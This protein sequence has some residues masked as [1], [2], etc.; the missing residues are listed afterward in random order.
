[1]KNPYEQDEQRKE[2]SSAWGRTKE[3]LLLNS[4][5]RK[6]YRRSES[7]IVTESDELL[8]SLQKIY[9]K[10]ITQLFSGQTF[11]EIALLSNAKNRTCTCVTHTETEMAIV[12]KQD[13]VY[14][15]QQIQEEKE[16]KN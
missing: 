2:I 6:F 16:A 10:Y 1:M 4:R 7:Q 12:M 11:G 15:Q 9:G 14:I 8:E 13:F 3:K 5:K